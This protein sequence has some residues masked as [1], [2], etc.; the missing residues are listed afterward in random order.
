[1]AAT[2]IAAADS[3]VSAVSLAAA[4]GFEVA[5]QNC[6]VASVG[7]GSGGRGEQWQGLCGCSGSGFAA[8]SAC[9]VSE[10]SARA[11]VAGL[12]VGEA[13]VGSFASLGVAGSNVSEV[14][15]RPRFVAAKP[16]LVVAYMRSYRT[17]FR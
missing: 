8:G 7:G 1:M 17:L 6:A 12:A 3:S 9:K 5:L 13:E 2:L 11:L 4:A 16:P 10:V 15:W 14:P